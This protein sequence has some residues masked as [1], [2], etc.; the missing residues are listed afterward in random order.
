MKKTISII[1][2]LGI[3]SCT[4]TPI[5]S[6]IMYNRQDRD[7]V[8][9][10]EQRIESEPIVRE[11]DVSL[12]IGRH[13]IV[14]IMVRNGTTPA[15]TRSLVL[16]VTQEVWKLYPESNLG[17]EACSI[18]GRTLYAFSYHCGGGVIAKNGW[19]ISGTLSH[20]GEQVGEWGKT[21]LC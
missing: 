20:E 8:A 11:S 21:C 2:L 9:E 16:K 7:Y 3:M 10:L 1:L 13:P 6:R 18:W 14:I 19:E 5:L 15:E 4:S 17:V 12:M